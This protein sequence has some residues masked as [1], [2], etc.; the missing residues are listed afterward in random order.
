[1]VRGS[2]VWENEAKRQLQ[3]VYEYIKQFSLQNAVKVRTD[4]ISK[5]DELPENPERYPPDK[6]KLNND[7][8]YRAFEIYRY[9]ISYFIDRDKI[10]IIQIRHTSRLPLVY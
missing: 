1:M 7:G 6:Y 2:V 10:I 3:E 5:T 4:I 9:R 8:S